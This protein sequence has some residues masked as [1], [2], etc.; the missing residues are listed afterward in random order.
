[1]S[2][3]WSCCN[4]D[5]VDDSAISSFCKRCYHLI[6][7]AG[8]C[9]NFSNLWLNCQ[10]EVRKWAQ[11]HNDDKPKSKK[12]N[13]LVRTAATEKKKRS[14]SWFPVIYRFH[15][16]YQTRYLRCCHWNLASR[17]DCN[18]NRV[19]KHHDVLNT[20]TLNWR[21]FEMNCER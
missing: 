16:S 11:A 14:L 3:N 12:G 8:R 6:S 10:S 9:L 18:V 20:Y 4:D 19:E 1:M 5:I 17:Q 2:I 13:T 21:K 15:S 7:Q